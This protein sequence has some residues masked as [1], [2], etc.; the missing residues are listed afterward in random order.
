[1]TIYRPQNHL[2]GTRSLVDVQRSSR[3]LKMLAHIKL[4]F[5]TSSTLTLLV[6]IGNI[7]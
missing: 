5:M 2:K 1:M 6:Y 4:L 3:L 7:K